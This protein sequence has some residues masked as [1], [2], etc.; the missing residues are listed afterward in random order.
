MVNGNEVKALSVLVPGVHLWGVF[1]LLSPGFDLR[2][3]VFRELCSRPGQQSPWKLP[4]SNQ[5]FGKGSFAGEYRGLPIF[6]VS[7]LSPNSASSPVLIK[8]FHCFC[9]GEFG[10]LKPQKKILSDQ[11]EK[12]PLLSKEW[13]RIPLFY[14]SLFFCCFAPKGSCSCAEVHDRTGG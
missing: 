10:H 4:I 3:D 14:L 6:S 13:G 7:F 2:A 12:E 11:R 1:S 5:R 8:D 9:G